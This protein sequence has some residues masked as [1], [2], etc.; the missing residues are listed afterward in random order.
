MAAPGVVAKVNRAGEGSIKNGNAPR[1]ASTSKD[2]MSRWSAGCVAVSALALSGCGASD[3][4]NPRQTQPMAPTTEVLE[5]SP[6]TLGKPF[7]NGSFD[8]TV[9]KV[10]FGVQVIK[11][12]PTA[13]VDASYK[14]KNGQFIV[15]H[16]TAKNVGNAA[17]A[18]SSSSSRLLAGSK[19]HAAGQYPGGR[20]Q[21]F[22][23]RQESGTTRTGWIAL[24]VPASIR[25]GT[26]SIRSNTDV[27]APTLMRIG[28]GQR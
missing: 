19:R 23:Q 8:I 12:D 28:E 13:N 26:L 4:L 16:A 9:T 27:V 15:V 7:Q 22:D 20:G 10:E 17:T 14:P 1:S 25:K 21:G 18:M 2:D 5:T 3:A 11:V 24:D 6:A